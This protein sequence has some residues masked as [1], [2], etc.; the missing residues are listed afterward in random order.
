MPESGDSIQAMKAGLM[1]IA[2]LFVLNKC[3]RPEADKAFISI[4]TTLQLRNFS[5]D[6]WQPLVLKT[7]ALENF[8]NFWVVRIY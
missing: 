6:A 4:Q 5:N 3:D 2:D 7:N 1:E 8:R